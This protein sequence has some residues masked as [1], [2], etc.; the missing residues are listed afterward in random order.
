M[1]E[2]CRNNLIHVLLDKTNDKRT[3][4]RQVSS[5]G[6]SD[7]IGKGVAVH[8]RLLGVDSFRL[9]ERRSQN[10]GK[11]MMNRHTKQVRLTILRLGWVEI[12]I[13]CQ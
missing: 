3:Y 9:R 2:S 1:S 7:E 4:L 13:D 5:K 8:A 6:S 10:G 12:V 11:I